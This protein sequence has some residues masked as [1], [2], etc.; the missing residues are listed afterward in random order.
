[1]GLYLCRCGQTEDDSDYTAI[2]TYDGKTMLGMRHGQGVYYYK[3]GDIYDGEWKIGMKHGYGLYTFKDG[4]MQRGFFY[5]DQYIG[6]NPGHLF[7]QPI[8]EDFDPAQPLDPLRHRVQRDAESE[9]R[10][11]MIQQRLEDSKTQ[12][13]QRRETREKHRAEMRKKY[14]Y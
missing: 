2:G 6:D 5:D 7:A 12:R 8:R 4:R 3:N 10:L 11:R 1:M 9:A 13:H 14:N